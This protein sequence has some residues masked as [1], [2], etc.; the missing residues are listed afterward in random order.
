M[1]YHLAQLNLADAIADMDS[2]IM[3]DFVN[4]TDRINALAG[5]S[6][7]FVWSLEER[8]EDEKE[9]R[10]AIFGKESLLVNMTVWEDKQSLFDFVYKSM[11]KDI[12]I[13]KKE[14]FAK[15]PKMHMVLWFVPVGHQPT[16]SEGKARLEHYRAHGATGFAFNFRDEFSP[17]NNA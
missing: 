3:A 17:N 2:P 14:W 7:G 5:K 15:M 12:M 6:P 4:N 16:I 10:V 1:N 8:S 13:R 9:D 11:H